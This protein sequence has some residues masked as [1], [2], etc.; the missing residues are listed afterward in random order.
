[1]VTA[2][3]LA[4]RFPGKAEILRE[5]CQSQHPEAEEH[6][7]GATAMEQIR[8]P[9]NSEMRQMSLPLSKPKMS[10]QALYLLSWPIQGTASRGAGPGSSR[11]SKTET[12]QATRQHIAL[13]QNE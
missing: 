13:G 5:G 3:D 1:M 4:R 10:P 12:K 9:N 6:V 11:V 7:K 2:A 8:A